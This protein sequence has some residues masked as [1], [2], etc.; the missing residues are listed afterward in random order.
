MSLPLERLTV[1]HDSVEPIIVENRTFEATTSIGEYV[2]EDYS[3]GGHHS[4]PSHSAINDC[5]FFFS[6][7]LY[8][9][10]QDFDLPKKIDFF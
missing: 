6:S 8:K 1:Y 5:F 9:T 7:L 2:Y 3:Y 4:I 10:V